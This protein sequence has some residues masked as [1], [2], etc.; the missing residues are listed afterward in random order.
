MRCED[1]RE[2][3]NARVDDE[4]SATEVDQ[5]D[6]HLASCAGCASEYRMLTDVHRVLTKADLKYQAP[7]LLQARIRGAISQT[8]VTVNHSRGGSPWWRLAAAGVV[9]AAMSSMLT[10]AATRQRADIPI[11]TE[12]TASHVRSLL[13]GHLTDIVSTNQHNVKPWFNGR[14]DLS[15]PV[16][17]LASKGF[18]LVGGRVDYVG[19]R[20][21]PVVVYAIRQHLINVYSWPVPDGAVES[22]R[23]ITRNGY[24]LISWRDGGM[25]HWAVSDLNEK[26]LNQLVNGF[27]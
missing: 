21:V 8:P 9:V 7:D 6:N 12:V 24:H 26:E 3:I 20:T 1:C 17:D 15:P 11:A 27:R 2:L 10:F 25:Q 5:V 22:P 14:V 19:G 13:P 18:A 4:L 23:T 16:P